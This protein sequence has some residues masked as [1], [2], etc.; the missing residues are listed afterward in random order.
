M[1]F[2]NYQTKDSENKILDFSVKIF[3]L[4]INI[5]IYTSFCTRIFIYD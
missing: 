3:N 4:L 1:Y 5:L 2:S